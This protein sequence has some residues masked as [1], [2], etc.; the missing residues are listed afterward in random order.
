M[1]RVAAAIAGVL[2]V[3]CLHSWA[4]A[5]QQDTGGQLLSGLELRPTIAVTG[6]F[7]SNPQEE[8]DGE[9]SPFARLDLGLRATLGEEDGTQA[10]LEL[11]GIL[12][13]FL[14]SEEERQHEY[15]A[16]F[17][18]AH[19]VDEDLRLSAG[20]LHEGENL[21]DPPTRFTEA[22]SRVEAEVGRF[23]IDLRGR[24]NE[25]RELVDRAEI[26]E[27]DLEV[28]DFR[29]AAAE[30]RTTFDTGRSF[31]PL[32]RARV[33]GFDYLEQRPGKPNRDAVE[34]SMMAGVEVEPADDLQI[35]AGLRRTERFFDEPGAGS[36]ARIGP[37]VRVTWDPND[38]LSLSAS[39]GHYFGEP[40][41]EEVLVLDT[42]FLEVDASWQASERL[43]L[44][45][46]AVLSEEEEVG[47][48]VRNVEWEAHA[49]ARWLL[50]ERLYLLAAA[51]VAREVPG[52][53]DADGF[54][55]TIVRAGLESTF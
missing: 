19:Q 21:T 12:I 2:S 7:D 13:E 39:Y 10:I 37:D 11:E 23:E 34:Y 50:R 4:A 33:T 48:G 38:R 14:D 27:D 17:E 41:F 35:E 29:S 45:G 44:T 15:T 55:R 22:W 9:G 40:T 1:R 18:L 32:L 5:Q 25:Y 26:V 16:E 24:V 49:D 20:L 46:G 42:T 8:A 28:F 54:R 3:P 47:T 30:L 6:G 53:P 51:R 52:D 43:R 36:Y 31:E